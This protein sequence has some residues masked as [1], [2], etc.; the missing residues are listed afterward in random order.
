MNYK[1]FIYSILI[2]LLGIT[3]VSCEKEEVIKEK[4]EFA[5]EQADQVNDEDYQIYS[6]F[7][8][9]EYSSKQVVIRQSSDTFSFIMSDI[10]MYE[11]FKDKFDNF[12][13]SMIRIH[14]EIN[15]TSVN[16]GEH[17]QSE[18]REIEVISTEEFTYFFKG[19]G[20]EEFYHFYKESNGLVKFSRIAYNVD[21]TQAVFQVTRHNYNGSI[22]HLEKVGGNWV[23]KQ[24][25]LRWTT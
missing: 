12:D 2:G 13:T 22:V 19:K 23:I 4:P 16:F 1:S 8:E 14:E 17:F 18:S 24:F 3:F 20:Y 25:E 10:G 5:L 15:K 11:Y 6:L 9:E 21:R 7:I